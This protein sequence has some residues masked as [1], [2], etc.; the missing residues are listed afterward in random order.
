MAGASAHVAT[1]GAGE[2]HNEVVELS[3]RPVERLHEHIG[4]FDG[5]RLEAVLEADTVLLKRADDERVLWKPESP[6]CSPTTGVVA[7]R[8]TVKRSR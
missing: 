4:A 5:L 6:S 3:S 8:E 2:E 1:R 7:E